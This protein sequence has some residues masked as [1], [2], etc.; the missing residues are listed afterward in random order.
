VDYIEEL[1]ESVIHSPVGMVRHLL[2]LHHRGA[3][4]GNRLPAIL[5]DE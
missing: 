3:I 1:E 2:H 4:V 5:I